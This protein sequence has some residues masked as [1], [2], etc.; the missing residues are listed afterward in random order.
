MSGDPSISR[1]GA[2]AKGETSQLSLSLLDQSS[3]NSSLLDLQPEDVDDELDM[4]FRSRGCPLADLYPGMVDRVKQAWSRHHTMESADVVLRKYRRWR[5]QP[6]R[7]S[8]NNSLSAPPRHNHHNQMVQREHLYRSPR[9]CAIPQPPLKVETNQQAR[10]AIKHFP[11]RVRKQWPQ[12]ILVMDF[13][14][15]SEAPLPTK[16]SLNETF[17]VPKT[18][19]PSTY[20]LS[21]VRQEGSRELTLKSKRLSLASR[22]LQADGNCKYVTDRPSNSRSP[23]RSSPLKSKM[24]FH[25]SPHPSLRSPGAHSMEGFSRESKRRRSMSE[26]LTSSANMPPKGFYPQEPHLSFVSQPSPKRSASTSDPRRLRRHLSFDSSLPVD[27]SSW[28][29]EQ[30]DNEFIKVYHWFV[31]QNKETFHQGPPCRFCA[32]NGDVDRDNS[33]SSSTSSSALAA[34]ALSPHRSLLR[35]RHREM[36]RDFH[37]QSKRLRGE[38]YAPSPGSKRHVRETLRR[39]LSAFEPEQHK[40]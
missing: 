29:R 31:C 17:D 9:I 25:T 2:N 40:H 33:P 36:S 13:A 18:K 20:N 11:G 16:V 21:P 6:S 26:S 10:S 34:L 8:V 1:A 24:I 14:G 3:R 4:T 27:G 12:P 15:V 28:S 32:R 5:Q 19:R 35:K 7:S 30:L 23:V 38:C 39:R 37:P 22:S